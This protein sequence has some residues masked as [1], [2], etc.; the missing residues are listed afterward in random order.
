MGRRSERK[1]SDII[2]QWRIQ[3]GSH[4]HGDELDSIANLGSR[5]YSQFKWRELN[6]LSLIT[7]EYKR[8]YQREGASSPLP[9]RCPNTILPI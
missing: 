2:K 8:I 1:Q 9:R 5:G 4:D 7:V 6:Q 3:R